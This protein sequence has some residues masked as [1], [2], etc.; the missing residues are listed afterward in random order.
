MYAPVKTSSFIHTAALWRR[1]YVEARSSERTPF[2]TSKVRPL[3]IAARYGRSLLVLGLIAGASLPDVAYILR[4]WLP[5]LVA[6]LLFITAMRV[7]HQTALGS[8]MALKRVITIILALQ[9]AA[10]LIALALLSAVQVMHHPFALAVVLMLAA[11][12]VT[13]APNFLIMMGAEPAHAMRIMVVGTA[14]FPITV[15]PVLWGLPT[16]DSAAAVG[17]ALRLVLVI[18]CA[19]GLGFLCRHLAFPKLTDAARTNLDGLSAIALAIVVVGLMSEIGPMLR[20]DLSGLVLWG[21]AVLCLNF[22]FQIATHTVLRRTKL[23]ES[24]A[25]SIISGNRN[26]A[27]FLIALPPDVTGPLLIFI[28]CYQIPMYLTPLLMRRLYTTTPPV[29]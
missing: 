29:L 3:Q 24:A 19:T 6:V 8:V 16:L 9:L 4:P 1:F 11:P 2:Q 22:G 21:T 10:P 17:A 18:L 7:G 5:E 13:G 26:I 12:S 25:I 20:S 15:L 28:G 23:P 27:L 14:V